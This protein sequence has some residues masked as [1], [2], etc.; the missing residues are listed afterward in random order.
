MRLQQEA[1]WLSPAWQSSRGL[2]PPSLPTRHEDMLNICLAIHMPVCHL[3]YEQGLKA[4]MPTK[5]PDS[6]TTPSLD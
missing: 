4:R 3:M 1:T 2:V 6:M 5:A